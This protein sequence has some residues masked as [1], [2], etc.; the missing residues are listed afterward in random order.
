MKVKVKIDGKIIE[1]SAFVRTLGNFSQLFIKYQ[2]RE[3]FIGN[4][5]EYLKG[6]PEYFE[7]DKRRI[8]K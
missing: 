8:Y 6:L 2:G 7:L 1:K 4:G 5:D 3:Y